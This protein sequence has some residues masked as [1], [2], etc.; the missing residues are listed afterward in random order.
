M[1]GG[2][3]WEG[4]SGELG[5]REKENESQRSAFSAT[6]F[7]PEDDEIYSSQI[8]RPDLT[9]RKD[10]LGSSSEFVRSP[11]RPPPAGEE[12]LGWVEL[13]LLLPEEGRWEAVSHQ[14]EWLL[15]VDLNIRKRVGGWSASGKKGSSSKRKTRRTDERKDDAFVRRE[16]GCSQPS[17]LD[18][19]YQ[20][21]K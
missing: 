14:L 9:S 21:D 16:H 18:I 17:D 12:E 8:R 2:V 19:V 3:G 1:G 4:G 6:H 7:D 11:N 5:R 15:V 13:G 20:K 10:S